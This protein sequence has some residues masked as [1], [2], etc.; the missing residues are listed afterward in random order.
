MCADHFE[1]HCFRDPDTRTRLIKRLRPVSVPIPT[2]FEYNLE[3]VLPNRLKDKSFKYIVS[4]EN[5]LVE[6]VIDQEAALQLGNE[7]NDDQEELKENVLI[8]QL[9]NRELSGDCEALFILDQPDVV[10][11]LDNVVPG[12]IEPDEDN[13]QLICEGCN[14]DL[15][16]ANEI[17]TR[18]RSNQTKNLA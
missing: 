7:Q 17:I 12:L 18:F 5:G 11:A 15:Q 9:C 6:V 14:R 10:V 13:S 3:K 1:S 8:C 4:S 2:L 16:T